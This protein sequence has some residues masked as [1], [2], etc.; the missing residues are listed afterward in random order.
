MN[1]SICP[2]IWHSVC[3]KMFNTIEYIRNEYD[4]IILLHIECVFEMEHILEKLNE[5]KYF[6]DYYLHICDGFGIFGMVQ[7]ICI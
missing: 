2:S 6:I 1:N 4:Q 7:R 5:I 3:G